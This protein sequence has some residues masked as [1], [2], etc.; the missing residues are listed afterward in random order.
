M[1]PGS[2]DAKA[3][4]AFSICESLLLC[5]A[6]HKILNETDIL[7]LLGDAIS[8]HRHAALDKT[9]EEAALHQ[10]AAELIASIAVGGGS[11]LD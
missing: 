11:P 5:L 1:M 2:K 10:Q 6:D 4:A 8:A 9:D 3:A 7:G